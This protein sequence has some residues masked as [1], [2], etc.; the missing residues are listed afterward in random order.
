MSDIDDDKNIPKLLQIRLYIFF[1]IS[2]KVVFK[3]FVY[4]L[5][6]ANLRKNS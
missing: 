4:F 5:R 1:T 2:H 6:T 3:D